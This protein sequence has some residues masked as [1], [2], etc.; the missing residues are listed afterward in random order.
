MAAGTAIAIGASAALAAGASAYAANKASS[1]QKAASAQNAKNVADT[2]QLNYEMFLQG[3]G[4]D[5]SAVLPMY[6]KM[7]GTGNLFEEQLG[8]D[9]VDNYR[10]GYKPPGEQ[11]TD[12]QSRIDKFAPSMAGARD[13]VT[14]VFDGTTGKKIIDNLTPVAAARMKSANVRGDAGMQALNET[15]N[16]VKAVQQGKGYS[17]DGLAS[18]LLGFSARRAINTDVAGA[19][20]SAELANAMDEKAARDYAIQLQLQNLG[21]P[22]SMAQQEVNLS[23]LPQRALYDLQASRMQ[24]LN[25]VR[26][27]TNQFQYQPMPTVQPI[28]STGQLV[29][30]GIGQAAGGI[31]N[32]LA[33]KQLAD[34]MMAQQQKYY[35]STPTQ[36]YQGSWDAT[37]SAFMDPSAMSLVA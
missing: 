10:A 21:L 14:G 1:A 36:G 24:P 35:Y 18:N 25:F 26:I 12:Y 16:E 27:G 20:S 19:R 6:L 33:K 37:P 28:A 15:L 29:G 17:G 22:Y 9:L 11:L 5:G 30:Q 4:S 31:G 34:Q 3:R 7:P 2:N 8:R 13:A 23:Q 32:Y